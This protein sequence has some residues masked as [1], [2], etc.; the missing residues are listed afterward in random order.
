MKKLLLG[1][2]AI[3][4]FINVAF[5]QVTKAD[6]EKIIAESGVSLDAVNEL[7]VAVSNF[8]NSVYKKEMVLESGLPFVKGSTVK[9]EFILEESYIKVIKTT[10]DNVSFVGI[11][12]YSGIKLFS[13]NFDYPKAG[14]KYVSMFIRIKD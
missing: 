12:P 1:V 9:C 8:P 11:Y 7:D 3:F 14:E 6:I 2:F 5:A 4:A 13:L 10:K